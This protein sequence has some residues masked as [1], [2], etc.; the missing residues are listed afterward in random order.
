M[1]SVREFEEMVRTNEGIFLVKFGAEWCGPCKTI[2]AGVQHEFSR[3]TSKYSNVKTLVIDIDHSMDL[4]AM[5]KKKKIISGI[6]AIMMYVSGSE[7][8]IYPTNMVTGSNPEGLRIFFAEA[9]N[10]A[11][12]ST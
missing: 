12:G 9:E 4:F 10:Y 2:E 11:M 6:P 5:L 1:V 8:G 7:D 3:L